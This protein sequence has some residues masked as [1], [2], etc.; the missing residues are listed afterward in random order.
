M[1]EHAVTTNLSD[2]EIE[3]MRKHYANGKFF[4]ISLEDGRTRI[5]KVQ[6]QLVRRG[7]LRKGFS[8]VLS[9]NDKWNV[10]Y[11][12]DKGKDLLLAMEDG[13]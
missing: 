13:R 10:Y 9:K 1:T 8:M 5:G 2:T 12:S 7:I 4:G 6:R 11:L 3:A